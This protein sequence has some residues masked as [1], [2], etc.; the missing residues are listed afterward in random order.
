MT[1][2]KVSVSDGRKRALMFVFGALI[3]IFF[4]TY[5]SVLFAQYINNHQEIVVLMREIGL[6]IFITLSVYFLFFAIQTNKNNS[7]KKLQLKS[8]RSRFYGNVDISN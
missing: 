2:A 5:I 7:E 1:A 8:K 3:I 6:A 4:Q